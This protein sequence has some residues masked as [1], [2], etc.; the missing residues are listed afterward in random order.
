[1]AA[2]LNQAWHAG[3]DLQGRAQQHPRIATLAHLEAAVQRGLPAAMA[4]AP[5]LVS[6]ALGRLHHALKLFGS[7]EFR[8]LLDLAP[9]WRPLVIALAEQ[10]PVRWSAGVL[11]APQW[12]AGSAV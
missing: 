9:V 10:V 3:L 11:E 6:E 2:T 4:A 7:I 8:G 12:L 1:A 5:T